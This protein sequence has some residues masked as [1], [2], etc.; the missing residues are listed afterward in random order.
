MVCHAQHLRFCSG[1]IE[2]VIVNM[3]LPVLEFIANRFELTVV[4]WAYM[5]CCTLMIFR[6]SC[7]MIEKPLYLMVFHYFYIDRSMWPSSTITSL[8]FFSHFF[9]DGA[10]LM[11]GLEMQLSPN[12]FR[13][14]RGKLWGSVGNG[15]H[16]LIS[17]PLWGIIP[18]LL[19]GIGF[20]LLISHCIIELF[21]ISLCTKYKPSG[22][23]P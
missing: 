10:V 2:E 14:R 5:S 22:V 12:R 15:L 17:G 3:L 6:A 16:C 20:S 4:F 9:S 13:R 23:N 8:N 19:P 1:T 7:N 18:Y 21:V 11:T